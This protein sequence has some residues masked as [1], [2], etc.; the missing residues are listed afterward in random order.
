ME[1]KVLRPPNRFSCIGL[2]CIVLAALR[3]PGSRGSMQ[4]TRNVRRRVPQYVDG[5]GGKLERGTTVAGGTRL[6]RVRVRPRRRSVPRSRFAR[7]PPLRRASRQEVSTEPLQ[8][9]MVSG[10]AT[11][12]GGDGA[13]HE[14]VLVEEELASP[15]AQRRRRAYRG[16]R[17]ELDGL[18]S[19][20]PDTPWYGPSPASPEGIFGLTP[21][22]G[23]R[24]R[25]R[26]YLDLDPDDANGEKNVR[27]GVR[28]FV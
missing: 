6:D 13:V 5:V 28:N 3:D 26:G 2:Q 20:P 4:D 14:G 9:V 24:G 18:W 21:R 1:Q 8:A 19:R 17:R 12:K 16:V 15:T 22:P 23:G 25:G 11:D 10:R 7:N 27:G